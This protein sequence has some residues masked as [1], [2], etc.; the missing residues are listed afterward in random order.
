MSR[1][2]TTV[3]P[4]ELT[5]FL[6]GELDPER[7]A[8]V[9]AALATHED[10]AAELKEIE[11][12]LDVVK[13]AL[14][15]TPATEDETL[16]LRR[17]E[18][19]V[20]SSSLT[21][22]RP[23]THVVHRRKVSWMAQP[24]N[25]A[26]A[27]ALAAT[28]LLA[29]G[30]AAW[31]RMPDDRK[32]SLNESHSES[33]SF[34]RPLT[35]ASGE[36]GA[37]DVSTSEESTASPS[38]GYAQVADE[39]VKLQR[40][41]QSSTQR[42]TLSDLSAIDVP[43]MPPVSSSQPAKQFSEAQ[44]GSAGGGPG[45]GYGLSGGALPG[46][47]PERSAPI[48]GPV[49]QNAESRPRSDLSRRGSGGEMG[50]G[51]GYGGGLGGYGSEGGALSPG[52]AMLGPS[53]S[54][55]G[56][57]GAMPIPSQ[58]SGA[59][60]GPMPTPG[61]H[62]GGQSIHPVPM[63]QEDE[64]EAKATSRLLSAGGSNGASP[65]TAL[66]I[67]TDSAGGM[68]YSESEQL[69]KRDLG[70]GA[71]P[72]FERESAPMGDR[73]AGVI[74]NEFLQVSNEPLSTFSIDVDTASYSKA[75]QFLMQYHTLPPA[76]AVRVEEFV[77]YFDYEYD[78]PKD[79]APFGAALAVTDCP[80]NNGHKL[81]RIALQATKIDMEKRPAANVVFLLDVS[82]SMDEPNK[83]PLVK[84]AMRMLTYQLKENDRV[85]MVVYAGAAGCVLEST[86]G[87][88]Q[89][90]ILAA[91]ER[92]SAGGSTNGGQ[93]IEL[94]YRMARENFIPGGVNR[95]VL[96]TDG[97]FN[98]G[99]TGTDEL[100]RMVEENAKS[101]VFLTVMGFGMG[102]TNDAMLEQ[103]SD[104]G[105]G[106]YK[107]IDTQREAQ[108]Q[109]VQQ[110]AGNLVT[111]AKDVKIQVEFNPSKVKSYRLIGYENRKL[112]AEDFNND[113]KDAG[114]IGA[115]HRV[116]ALYE[117]A[118]VGSSSGGDGTVDPLR[119]Q[120]PR[121]PATETSNEN[122]DELLA[123][124]LRYKQPERDTSKL[125][126]FPLKDASTKFEEADRDFRW[127]TSVA[128]F[129]MTL[130]GSKHK[131]NLTWDRLQEMAKS[132]AGVGPDSFRAEMLDMIREARSLSPEHRFEPPKQ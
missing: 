50:M 129:A 55:P 48:S 10:L 84:E 45:M 125:L 95:V 25:I 18:D 27:V 17:I 67:Q 108:R 32:I 3:E 85:A 56:Q 94:A 33:E 130:R 60:A 90:E 132:A 46:A 2:H 120:Q 43:Y 73:Y 75:R 117:I 28:A 14:S 103:I 62:P 29:V 78:G 68:P 4:W 82:G 16:L 41:T 93:G 52:G 51:G 81:V 38:D 44:I 47:I 102:N 86:R 115:G 66:S 112:A 87:D 35:D 70:R 96:C 34:E 80:W 65:N 97:D 64:F 113:K 21:L 127:A 126:T 101:K 58:S 118:T 31:N 9:E 8:Q 105:N 36:G 49:V 121:K 100:V 122:S 19:D 99:V 7:T 76:S 26:S 42:E 83:L 119:Y 71:M 72:R 37:K 57:S 74:E 15:S 104:R 39:T 69:A 123:V 59:T 13:S 24:R 91:I 23:S 106:V 88:K 131:G 124:K 79:D 116:T 12:T 5:A 110:L 107:F 89:S 114:E 61:P 22:M 54:I 11:T 53:G 20:V 92:L 98:V 77:N 30:L 40:Q 111:V 109:M 63:D 1:D 6:L 128:A